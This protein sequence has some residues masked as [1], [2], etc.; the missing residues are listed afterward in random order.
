M[1]DTT[2]SAVES[3]DGFESSKSFLDHDDSVLN[4]GTL[5]LGFGE[6]PSGRV[7]FYPGSEGLTCRG[8]TRHTSVAEMLMG[9]I[10]SHLDWNVSVLL[11]REL[12]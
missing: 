12:I 5:F 3:S 9:P 7:E 11:Y 8:V 10:M 6:V 2:V 4:Y 1:R